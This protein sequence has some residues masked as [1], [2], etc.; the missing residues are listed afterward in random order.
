MQDFKIEELYQKKGREFIVERVSFNK[1]MLLLAVKI[2]GLQIA[3]IITYFFI[4]MLVTMFFSDKEANVEA[5]YML[6]ATVIT[7]ASVLLLIYKPLWGLGEE[8]ATDLIIGRTKRRPYAGL[9]VGLYAIS[10][11]ILAWAVNLLLNFFTFNF[12][13]FSTVLGYL[14]YS[15]EPYFDLCYIYLPDGAWY[16]PFIYLPAMLPI[17][18]LCHIAYRNGLHGITLREKIKAYRKAKTV[19]VEK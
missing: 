9:A 12:S 8:H 16:T 2:L 1:K 13:F 5:P 7:Q 3:S 11:I 15:W 4:V 17:P 10:P 18:A 14:L 19:K 6:I